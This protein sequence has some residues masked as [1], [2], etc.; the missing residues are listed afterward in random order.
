MKILLLICG[1][2]VLIVSAFYFNMPTQQDKDF[3]QENNII[4]K[5][6]IGRDINGLWIYQTADKKI[7]KTSE[8][9]TTEKGI[10]YAKL[11]EVIQ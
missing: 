2:I 5:V 3:F 7:I 6:P 4:D 10:A 1:F 8:Y 9:P 11:T